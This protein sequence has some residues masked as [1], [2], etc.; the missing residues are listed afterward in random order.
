MGFDQDQRISI[1]EITPWKKIHG[2][3][4]FFNLCGLIR[5]H[6]GARD[7]MVVVDVTRLE[8]LELLRDKTSE[9]PLPK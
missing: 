7:W 8:G 2:R 6:Y 9:Y 5:H 4:Y 3:D 1:T